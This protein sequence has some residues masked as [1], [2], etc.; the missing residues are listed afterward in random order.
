MKLKRIVTGAVALAA[1]VLVAGYAIIASLNVEQ[2]AEVAKAEVKAATGRDLTVGGP[3]GLRISLDPSIILQDVGFANAPW[4]SRPQ[5]ARVKLLEI[6]VALLPLLTGEVVVKRLVVIEPDILLETDAQ[7]RGNW[8]FAADSGPAVPPDRGGGPVNLPDVQAFRIQGGQLRLVDATAGETLR[9]DVT[10]AVG[11]LPGDG[12]PRSLRLAAVYNGHPIVV[13]GRFSGLPALLS[14]APAPVDLT[15][16]AGGT[17]VVIKGVAGNL[18]G[19]ASAD[20]AVAAFGGNLAG[21]SP[22]VDSDLPPLGPFDLSS[23]LKVDG[24]DFDFSGLVLTIGG[25]DVTGNAALSMAGDRPMVKAALV[26]KLL[27]LADFAGDVRPA[28]G[29]ADGSGKVFSDAPLPLAALQAVDGRVKLDAERLR[30]GGVTLEDVAATL[31]LKDGDL[32][33]EPLSAKLA[34]GDL[35]GRLALTQANAPADAAAAPELALTLKGANIDFGDLLKQAAV[36]DGVGGELELDVDLTGQGASPHAIAADLGGHVQAV[37]L[38]GT[39]DNG[40]LSVLSAGLGDITGP[41]FG[42]SENTRLE[43]FVSRFELEKGQA[44]SRALVL[45]TGAFAVAGRG[46]LDLDGEHVSLAF[47]TQTS[48][49]SLASLA[50]PFRVVGPLA[51]PGV[52]PDPIGAAIGVVG[53]VGD[54]AQTGGNLVGG[55]VDAVGGLIGTGPIIGHIGSDQTLCG[56][57]LAAIGRGGAQPKTSGG[58][59]DEVGDAVKGVGEGIEKGLKGLTGE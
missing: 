54:V 17:T 33:V 46:G 37:S 48:Q 43:C 49:P 39:L 15:L 28:E 21:L 10:E 56:E 12:G 1:A 42:D 31:V 25:S 6:E 59:A 30:A 38:D 18:T 58:L 2:V 20:V 53:T 11:A 50:V 7:G 14:G 8:D 57:A 13:E 32:T 36:S 41:L 34:G 29:T 22:L 44:K 3:V 51:D 47:D 24:E 35:G 4:G 52:V 5:M 26:A 55:A 16:Q 45:D 19:A 9:L 27:D 40:L 23:N